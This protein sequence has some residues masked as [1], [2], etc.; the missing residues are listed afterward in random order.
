MCAGDRR[1]PIGVYAEYSL[2]VTFKEG[3][4]KMINVQKGKSD[5]ILKEIETEQELG[6]VLNL[7]Y[8]ILGKDD[9]EL[10]G[11][12]AWHKRLLDG[13]SPLVYAIKDE[14]IISAVL[15]RAESQDSLIIGFAA[16]SEDYR[17]QG[18][19]KKLMYFFEDIARKKGFKYITLGSMEDA[20]YEK[21]GY[22]VIFQVQ[23]QKI[24]QKI[25]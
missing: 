1:R 25:L 14:K 18:I 9:S 2:K 11:Y 20:F 22:K 8:D 24:Y 6:E 3:Q 5:T 13:L 15:G 4:Q 10:Y 12:D 19:T 16:C 7:C 21:C 17:R 23:R